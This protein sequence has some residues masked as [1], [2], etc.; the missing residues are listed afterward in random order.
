MA[1]P[2]CRGMPS[3]ILEEVEEVVEVGRG[4]PW[5]RVKRF[6]RV[7]VRRVHSL[8]RLKPSETWMRWSR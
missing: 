5:G 8:N 6:A 7:T 1:E 2:V 3:S 4:D